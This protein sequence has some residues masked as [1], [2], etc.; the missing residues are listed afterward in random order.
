MGIK[1]NLPSHKPSAEKV[2][3][4][5]KSSLIELVEMMANNELSTVSQISGHCW[6][7][8]ELIDNLLDGQDE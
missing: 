4:G 7:K 3:T 5:M 6:S 1:E 2:L 8:I